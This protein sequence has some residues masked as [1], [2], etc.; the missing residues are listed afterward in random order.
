M[1]RA[2]RSN[3]VDLDVLLPSV[4]Q[5]LE[6][7]RSLNAAGLAKAG[8]PKAQQAELLARLEAAGFERTKSGVRVALGR[9]IRAALAERE[10][11]PL[12][13]LAKATRGATQKEC[14]AAVAALLAEGAGRLAFRGKVEVLAGPRVPALSAEQLSS[15]AR[16]CKQ[17]AALSARALKRGN[18]TLLHD[19]V[20]GQLLD[21]VAPPR[22]QREGTALADAILTELRRSVRGA[23]GLSYVPDAVRALA[24]HPLPEV[25][26]LLLDAARSG[27]IELQPDSGLDRLTQEEKELCP[28]GPHGT[29]L[30]WARLPEGTP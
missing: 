14:K 28:P 18:V 9:Q 6:R 29:R 20:R 22:P 25:H 30:S 27:R 5:T 24:T 2:A 23:V 16:A 26:R 8:V 21:F 13:Q 7:E 17:L 10:T 11:L 19:D 3:A 12:A 1:A 4:Q 15:L